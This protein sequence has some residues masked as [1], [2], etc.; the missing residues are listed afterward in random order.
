MNPPSADAPFEGPT[1]RPI[2]RDERAAGRIEVAPRNAADGFPAAA[3]HSRRVRFLRIALPAAV[4]VAV[5]AY[6]VVTRSGTPAGV[7]EVNYDNIV[8]GGE[9]TVIER[10][11]L[12]GYQA[13]GEAYALEADRATQRND[14]PDVLTLEGVRANFEL[15]DGINAAF[16]APAGDYDQRTGTMRLSGGLTMT[17]DN[18]I[19]ATMETI[20][21]DVANGTITTDR[22]FTL[23][24]D[25]VTIEGNTLDMTTERMTIGGGVHAVMTMGGPP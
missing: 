19:D 1:R 3:R 22:P 7:P 15:P 6:V 9:A 23:R 16:T 2:R 20:V 5:A 18:G 4:I 17:L 10:P 8:F 21:V 24:A 12:T 25:G 14:D 11:R 13:G